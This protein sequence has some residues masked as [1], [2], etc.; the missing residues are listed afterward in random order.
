MAI[1]IPLVL[2]AAVGLWSQAPSAHLKFDLGGGISAR[3]YI[4]VTQST[5]YSDSLGYGFEEGSSVESVTRDEGDSIRSNF[6]TGV[7]QP[8]YFS[9]KLPEE[10]NYK[11]TIISGDSQA[12]SEGRRCSFPGFTLFVVPH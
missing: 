4:K 6:I 10:G 7:G 11:V 1:W 5:M 8:F 9:V 2:G 12:D 3:G